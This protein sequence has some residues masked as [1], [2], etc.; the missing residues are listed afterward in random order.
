MCPKAIAF[1]LYTI[2]LMKGFTGTLYFPIT[3]ETCI[4]NNLGH[5]LNRKEIPRGI[6]RGRL[7]GQVVGEMAKGREN[8][9][10]EGL[11]H[12]SSLCPFS[13]FHL[14][15]T[16]QEMLPGWVGAVFRRWVQHKGDPSSRP[17]STWGENLLS[18]RGW[19]QECTHVLTGLPLSQKQ[20]VSEG[21]PIGGWGAVF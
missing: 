16:G 11:T 13:F 19:A 10:Q 9:K 7:W 5:N 18:G 20:G 3:G 12:I 14:L 15:E 6:L 4:S 8:Q 2:S 21:H 1:L 17:F